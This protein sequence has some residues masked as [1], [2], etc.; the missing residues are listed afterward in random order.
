VGARGQVIAFEPE[1]QAYN[2]L[3]ENLRLNQLSN[4]RVVKKALGEQNA[5]GRI[6]VGG[7]A[8]PSL[9]A[10]EEDALQQTA[11]QEVDIVEGDWLVHTEGLPIPRAVKIDVEGFECSVLR[12]LRQTLAD[13]ACVLL[14]CE[15]HPP[16]LPA[17]VGPSTIIDL[18]KS[19]GFSRVEIPPQAA[20]IHLVASKGDIA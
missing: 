11:S 12:G 17:G 16:F 15:I 3:H 14:C 18:T 4:V 9:L 5:S 10:H 13:P 1:D 6:F 2:Q 19:L 20:R 8:C 7:E